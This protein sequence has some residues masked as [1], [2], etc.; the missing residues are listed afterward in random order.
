MKNLYDL[1]TVNEMKS[2][3]VHLT[4]DSV[5]QWGTMS[6]AQVVAHLCVSVQM[7]LGEVNPRR[8][9]IGRI[10]GPLIKSKVLG[11]DEPFRRN[12]PTVPEMVIKDGRDLDAERVRLVELLDRF[13]ADGPAGCTRHPHAFFG[14]MTPAEWGILMYKHMDHHLRQFGV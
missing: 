11:N 12:S 14:P 5:R 8:A 4:P 9:L 3:I 13:A 6:A 7:G 1:A 2:R 10:V